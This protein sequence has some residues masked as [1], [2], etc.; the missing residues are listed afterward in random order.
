MGLAILVTT[1]LGHP[2]QVSHASEDAG[3]RDWGELTGRRRESVEV[4]VAQGRLIGSPHGHDHRHGGKLLRIRLDHTCEEGV[5]SSQGLIRLLR[6][7][8]QVGDEVGAKFQAGRQAE[9]LFL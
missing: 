2:F 8:A 1:E 4:G 5:I 3:N 6:I 9:D 7:G